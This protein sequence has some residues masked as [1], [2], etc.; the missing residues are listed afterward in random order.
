MIKT[1]ILEKIN[2]NYIVIKLL[3]NSAIAPKIAAMMSWPQF[4]TAMIG[5][6]IAFGFLKILAKFANN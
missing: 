3:I 1:A 2:I 5:G 4:A 6:V